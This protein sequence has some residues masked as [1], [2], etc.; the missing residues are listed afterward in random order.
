M[1]AISIYFRRILMANST[2][3][4][5]KGLT[6]KD[7][8]TI[9]IFTAIY[10]IVS[11][12]GGLPFAPNPVLTFYMPLGQALLSG[13][14]IMLLWAKVPKFGVATIL[15]AIVGLIYFVLGMHW[16]MDLGFAVMALLADLI[17]GTRKY[18]SKKINI[19]A[20]AVMCLGPTGTYIV[21][22]LDPAGWASTMLSKGTP[23]DY[24]DTMKAAAPMWLLFVILIGSFAV[25]VFSGWAGSKLLK[26]QFEKAGITA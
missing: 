15:G 26:K 11:L 19:L 13:P 5:K 7:L 16:A 8:V 17:A 4:D 14:V 24:I 23:V 6:V 21:F 22:F 12:L 18:R 2:Y 9:G 10:F 20:Y 1:L 25:G 3:L